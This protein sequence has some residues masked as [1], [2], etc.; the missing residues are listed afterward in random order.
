M[1]CSQWG[2]QELGTTEQLTVTYLRPRGAL[3]RRFCSGMMKRKSDKIFNSMCA[4][5]HR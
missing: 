1:G 2:C 3:N 5:S 4:L